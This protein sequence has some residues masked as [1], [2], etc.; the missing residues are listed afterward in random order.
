MRTHEEKSNQRKGL[1]EHFQE[2]REGKREARRNVARKR[3]IIPVSP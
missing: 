3:D 2:S 1:E